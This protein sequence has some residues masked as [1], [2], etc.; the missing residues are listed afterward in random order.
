MSAPDMESPPALGAEGQ[1]IAVGASAGPIY[2]IRAIRA[3]I[4]ATVS[5]LIDVLDTLDLID[6][7]A[8]LEDATDAEDEGIRPGAWDGPGCPAA[9][10]D[11]RA[12]PEWHGRGRHKEACL[13]GWN[14]I[15]SEDS[16]EDD[17]DRA[18]DEGEPDFAHVASRWGA[19]CAIADPDAEHD[20]CEHEDGL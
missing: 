4:Q 16:E 5:P 18:D 19:G 3:I 7:D 11:D 8:D 2:T 6:G 20:G 12:W 15:A 14:R 13:A 17:G 10:T 1:C 9:D